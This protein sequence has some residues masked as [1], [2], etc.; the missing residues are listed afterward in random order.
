MSIT[1]GVRW[2]VVIAGT[3]VCNAPRANSIAAR[4]PGAVFIPFA[5][6]ETWTRITVCWVYPCIRHASRFHTCPPEFTPIIGPVASSI[7][8]VIVRFTIISRSF[9]APIIAAYPIGAA[10]FMHLTL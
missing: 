9:M 5:A 6:F 4:C 1:I 10:V 7:G 8:T 2:T 3:V